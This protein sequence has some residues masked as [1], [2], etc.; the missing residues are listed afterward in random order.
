MDFLPDETVVVITADAVNS[1]GLQDSYR[2]VQRLTLRQQM[3]LLPMLAEA[4]LDVF[5]DPIPDGPP[6]GSTQDSHVAHVAHF[7]DPVLRSR[8]HITCGCWRSTGAG[9]RRRIPSTS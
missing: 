7:L 5:P 2:L 1:L 8:C 9:R 6:I 3:V 4:I